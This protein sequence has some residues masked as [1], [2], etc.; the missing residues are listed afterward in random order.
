[1]SDKPCPKCG[2]C[3]KCGRSNPVGVYP[4]P[5]YP[6]TYPYGTQPYRVYPNNWPPYYYSNV[7]RGI[8][9][10]TGGFTAPSSNAAPQSISPTI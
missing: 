10:S 6:Y 1:M 9:N 5:V 8:N 2:H 4:Y 3:D 7:T